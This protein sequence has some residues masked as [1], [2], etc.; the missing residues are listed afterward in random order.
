MI[1]FFFL[2]QIYAVTP[3]LN[4][5]SKIALIRDHNIMLVFFGKIRNFFS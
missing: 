1:L 5:I 2:N 3:H 4:S